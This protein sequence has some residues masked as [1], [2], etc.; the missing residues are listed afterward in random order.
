M[1]N[2]QLAELVKDGKLDIRLNVQISSWTDKI[3]IFNGDAI[4]VNS[5]AS[6]LESVKN[7]PKACEIVL[8]NYSVLYKSDLVKIVENIFKLER[9]SRRFGP[10]T[11]PYFRATLSPASQQQPNE[12]EFLNLDA[13]TGS[14][15]NIKVQSQGLVQEIAQRNP[16]AP[17]V[18]FFAQFAPNQVNVNQQ[19][20]QPVFQN[21]AVLQPILPLPSLNLQ[22]YLARGLGGVPGLFAVPPQADQQQISIVNQLLYNNLLNNQNPD[23]PVFN[24]T[25]NQ[26]Q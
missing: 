20:L 22:Q 9:A 4:Y 18:N 16:F 5:E 3:C 12:N 23:T 15:A 2:T 24:D 6:L 17:P 14:M 25:P 10:N 26:N 1:E 19:F 21:Q 7:I 11:H 13:L 8:Q